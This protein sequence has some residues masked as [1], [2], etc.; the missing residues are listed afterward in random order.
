MRAFEVFRSDPSEDTRLCRSYN[1]F[2][3]AIVGGHGPLA[4]S[5][6]VSVHRI[7]CNS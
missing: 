1:F 7:A 5:V 2:D 6:Y 4:P 3:T